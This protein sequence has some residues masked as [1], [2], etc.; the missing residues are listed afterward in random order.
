[1]NWIVFPLVK[2]L[3]EGVEEVVKM[4]RGRMGSDSTVK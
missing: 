3:L 1:M 2:R 4:Q